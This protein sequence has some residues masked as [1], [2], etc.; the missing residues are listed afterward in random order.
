MGKTKDLGHLAHIVAY[1]AENHITV[2][3]GITMHTNQLV[4]SQAWVTTALG[5]YA[6][7]SALS[8]YVPTSRTITINGTTF[9][10]SANRSWT[11]TAGIASVSGTSPIN[12]STT[13]GA[14]TVSISQA[15]TSTNGFLSSTD[16]N[17]FNGKQ[18]A[19]TIG[20][21]VSNDTNLITVTGGTGAIIGSG[22][23]LLVLPS[24][25]VASGISSTLVTTAL[26]YTPVTN[27][28]TI[29]INGTSFD[30]SANRSWTIT[31][32]ETDTLATVTGRGANTSTQVVFS[33]GMAAWNATTPG[34]SVG[35]IQIGAANGNANFGGAIT[36]AARDGGGGSNAQ[37]GIYVV[38]DGA[39]GTRMYFATTDAY[40]SG[41][42]TAMSISETG[43]VNFVRANATVQGN[44]LIHA[45][46]IGSQSVSTASAASGATFL[47]QANAT[48]GARLQIGGNGDP[49][50]VANIAVVQATDGNLHMDSG[51]GKNMYLNYYRNGIIYL[52]GGTYFI[53]ANGSQYNGN[54]ATATTAGRAYPL[55]VGGVD[56]N[57]NWSG[58]S[59][60]PPWLWGGSDGS[61]MYVYN[62]SNFSVNYATSAGSATSA[63]YS[64]Y[65][66][67]HYNGGVIS[68]PQTYFNNGIGLKVAMTGHWSVWSDTLWINGYTGGDVPNMCALHFLRN[69]APR[70][71]ISAQ[72]HGATSYGTIYEVITSYNIASQTV[73]NTNSV[74]SAT[75]GSYTWTDIQ[76]FL[77]NNGG[78][79]VNNSNSAKLQA[80]STG[81][82]SAFMSFHR[83]GAYAI[84]MGLDN[85][86]YFRI[87]GWSAPANRLQLNMTSG[88]LYI[89]GTGFFGITGAAGSLSYNATADN[90]YNYGWFRNY[91]DTGLYNQDFGCH[92]RKQN[93]TYGT[94]EI[95]GYNKNGYAGLD[96]V[97]PQ[98]FRN[99]LMYE[100]GNGGVYQQNGAGW[101]FYF[102]RS[103]N[104]C[105]GLSGSETYD[106][107]RA[108][109]NG[110]HRIT[111]DTWCD[112]ISY[113]VSFNPIS[114]ARLKENV[115]TVDNALDKILQLRGV[116]YS[117]IIDTEQKKH[118]GVIA[119]E[120]QEVCPE[121]V[122]YHEETDTLTVSYNDLSGVFIE[123]F[124]ELN[125]K[126]I[127]ANARI[128][129]LET[130]LN[131]LLNA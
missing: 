7:S 128:E 41:S 89:S 126:L 74:S 32:T 53:S 93:G 9:D 78:Q 65:L 111:N 14:A 83:S 129:M 67:P 81:G 66:S 55:R 49:G 13:S 5:S 35:T 105:L 72:S 115:V 107:V 21:I 34:L 46:N 99:N 96:L 24:A 79:A 39:Y 20:N 10:L 22:V 62:P 60:Q 102:Q 30:L 6:L 57:F 19:L 4:A 25:I 104:D 101:H 88:D 119:Q 52:N 1:D 108:C 123:G 40:V 75:G 33:G 94:W 16:W 26:G 50:A 76:Y 95:F 130:K 8:S 51:T 97:D 82:N 59:G 11:I 43:V 3:A 125:Q 127:D 58:Q 2:P 114:D 31:A 64:S 23:S 12:V 63:V 113:A 27:A 48:W 117:W 36:F 124:K 100:S 103:G 18:N 86:N 37:A 80:Y 84:N 68:N 73:A 42:K 87:G 29:T 91:G 17:T 98:D 118:I 85:D 112:A 90:I 38:S 47:T 70:M 120:V 122:L 61:N 15:N 121:A 69:G 54:A 131:Q 106:W 92:F 71:A 28:R 110:K 44:G 109:T 45:G 56:L 116:Y 77:T